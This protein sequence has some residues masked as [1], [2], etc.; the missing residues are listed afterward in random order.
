MDAVV[1]VLRDGNSKHAPQAH[2]CIVTVYRVV[3]D[4]SVGPMEQG[5]RGG[6]P[7]RTDCCK[8]MRVTEP[9]GD[10]GGVI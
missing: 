10:I 1:A 7:A 3:L 5:A 2:T 4:G 9:L 8:P 6:I